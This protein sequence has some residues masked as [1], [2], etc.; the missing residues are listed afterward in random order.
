M[1]SREKR[2][3]EEADSILQ[4]QVANISIRVEEA[5]FNGDSSSFNVFLNIP[6]FV[7]CGV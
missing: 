1:E 3:E 7:L 5:D 6:Y 2:E 4:V